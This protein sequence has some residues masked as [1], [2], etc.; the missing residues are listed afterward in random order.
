METNH[1]LH[2]NALV[3]SKYW[4]AI[5]SVAPFQPIK[6]HRLCYLTENKFPMRFHNVLLR[7]WWWCCARF[8]HEL[9]R[10]ARFEFDV[11]FSA[12]HT[13]AIKNFLLKRC[14]LWNRRWYGTLLLLEVVVVVLRGAIIAFPF[15]KLHIPLIWPRKAVK[16]L[17]LTVCKTRNYFYDAWKQHFYAS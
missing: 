5:S 16:W 7:W 13:C 8:F 17:N 12:S 9:S 2:K 6:T 3:S 15:T 1:V 10:K 4:R 11:L 14:W